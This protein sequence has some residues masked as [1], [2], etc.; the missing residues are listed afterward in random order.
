MICRSSAGKF[1]FYTMP[2]ALLSVKDLTLSTSKKLI[3]G[4][5]SFEIE[6]G[7]IVALTG[8]SGKGKTSIA[9]AI[10][11]HFTQ[12]VSLQKG[13][14]EFQSKLH[15]PIVLPKDSG[16][17]PSIRGKEIG[18]IQQDVFGAFNPTQRMGDQILSI[19]SLRSGRQITK[20]E[21]TARLSETG[22]S[23]FDRILQ[24]YPHQLS[25]GQ[26]Q[27][28][29]I[30]LMALIK[31][32]LLLVDEPTSAIDKLTQSEILSLFKWLRNQFNMAIVCITHDRHVVRS[33]ADR[34]INLDDVQIDQVT[35]FEKEKSGGVQIKVLEVH[36]L[37]FR[38]RYGGIVD[39]SGA[40]IQNI[41][42][43]INARQ[44]LAIVGPS[45]SGKST[46][47]QLLMGLFI[48]QSGTVLLSE[49]EINYGDPKQIKHLRKS[50]QLVMQ[51][52]R[53]SLHPYKT[54]RQLLDEVARFN[55]SPSYDPVQVLREV[56][57]DGDVLTK[58]P[59][60]LSGGECLRVSIARSLM[61][62]PQILICDESTSALDDHTRDAIVSMLEKLRN[63]HQLSL[64]LISHDLDVIRRMADW[65]LIIDK[66][67][68]CE[69]GPSESVL[70]NSVSEL[71]KKFFGSHATS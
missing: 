61:V 7:E 51:D 2:S 19:A 49:K 56:G 68:I 45:G 58:L 53:G 36:N 8:R 27:R 65:I 3:V 54:I 4:D 25:G 57:L 46:I 69:S 1:Y 23:D 35:F 42:F 9:N 11:G 60:Q 31:P 13:I 18:F 70:T 66:G 64:I 14:I 29:I 62:K 21:F 34:E 40:N 47:A 15:G 44:C 38:H 41:S 52:G 12:G 28:C 24:S 22:L 32:S 16:L 43:T 10:L 20:E 59:S 17:W 48:P 63:E 50:I 55:K 71:G 26:L 5:I 6:A 37:S 39:H 30:A 33:L 67:K